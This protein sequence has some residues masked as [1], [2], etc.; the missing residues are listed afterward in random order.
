MT[1]TSVKDVGSAFANLFAGSAQTINTPAGAASFKQVLDN[2]V[3]KD[4]NVSEMEVQTKPEEKNAD[5]EVEVSETDSRMEKPEKPVEDVENEA[6]IE[7]GTTVEKEAPTTAEAD[8]SGNENPEFSEEEMAAMME[9]LNT[10]ATQLMQN[11]AETFDVTMEELQTVMKELEMVETDVLDSNKLGELM[12]QLGGASDSYA[13]VT[14]EV[15]YD[16]Y[17]MVMDAQK[18]A[19]E[20]VAQDL[21]VEQQQLD[22]LISVEV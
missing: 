16:K 10:V 8:T 14:D 15:L 3:D 20:T 21:G 4:S 18:V 13:L 5:A 2:Q 1:S 9:V 7:A 6:E 12:L 17:C 19:L 11:V 22:A